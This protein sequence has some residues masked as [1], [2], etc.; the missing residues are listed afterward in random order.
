[1]VAQVKLRR[2]YFPV[3][4]AGMKGI[5]CADWFCMLS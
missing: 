2:A 3:I 4:D 5:V 1:L